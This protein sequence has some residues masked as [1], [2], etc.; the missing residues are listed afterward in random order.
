MGV[1]VKRWM[2]MGIIALCTTSS[3]LIVR[4][5]GGPLAVQIG[6]ALFG[7]VGVVF[8]AFW[9]RQPRTIEGANRE[10]EIARP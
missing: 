10:G 8:V 2:I 4:F 9:R 3:A 5:G 6:I 1:L 7:L